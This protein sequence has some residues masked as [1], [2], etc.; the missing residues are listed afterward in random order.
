[1]SDDAHS[2]KGLERFCPDLVEITRL[3]AQSLDKDIIIQRA[4]EHVYRRLGKRAR[5]SMVEDGRLVLKYWVGDYDED[6]GAH[7][8]VVKKS[9][10]WKV[11]ENGKPV[12]FTRSSD[13]NGWEHT[14]KERIKIKAIVPLSYVNARTQK[15]VRFGVLVVDSGKIQTPIND[16]EFEYLHVMADLIGETMGKA[17]LVQ[18][19]LESY[20]KREELVKSMA[21]FLRNRFMVIG[22]FARRLR[23]KACPGQE[24]E[25]A[26]IIFKEIGEME[27][28]LQTLEHMW[29]EEEERI[30]RGGE[31][32]AC[33]L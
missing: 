8:E 23:E 14:L 20:E 12:N 32:T 29:A 7:P 15:H 33:G 16:E 24:Q 26:D 10:V 9:I 2:Y 4:L 13:T 18:E 30:G 22:G 25:Y 1:M 5:C 28:C 19:L 31:P 27:G 3:L 17:D 21:H 6:L 11:F